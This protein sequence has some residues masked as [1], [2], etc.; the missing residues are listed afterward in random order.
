MP[1]IVT[2]QFPVVAGAVLL[3]AAVHYGWFDR[4]FERFMAR[5]P[6][7]AERAILVGFVWFSLGTMSIM[8][9]LTYFT[10]R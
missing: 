10:V 6:T 7:R 1:N 5:P 9:F 8:G 3:W 4:G 2:I